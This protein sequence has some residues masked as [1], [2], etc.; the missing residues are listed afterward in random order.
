MVGHIG[1]DLMSGSP[2]VRDVCSSSGSEFIA[3]SMAGE[4]SPPRRSEVEVP[5]TSSLPCVC[6]TISF[7]GRQS[8]SLVLVSDSR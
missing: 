4:Y 8:L 1:V 5:E 6:V 7:S 2:L 3:S